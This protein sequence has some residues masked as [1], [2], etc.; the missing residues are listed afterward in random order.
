MKSIKL[1]LISIFAVLMPM[2]SFSQKTA[3]YNEV[4][5]KQKKGKIDTYITQNGEEFSVGDTITLGVSF[6]KEQFDFIMQDAGHTYEPLS[7]I[8][9]NT[10]VVINKMSIR[11]KT[12][13]VET[14]KPQGYIYSL[15]ID[16]FDSA[17]L[18]G[19]IK[20][21]LITSKQAFK[22]LLK[23]EKKLELGLITEEEYER[24]KKNLF[25][26]LIH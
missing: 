26:K 8:A 22:E 15:I 24:K 20:T 6:S 11:S 12:V 17:V 16:N 10:Q 14:T 3:T 25:S 9:S 23:W 19:E 4:I 21:K 18:N 13:Q 2:S 5:S 1:M 7:N